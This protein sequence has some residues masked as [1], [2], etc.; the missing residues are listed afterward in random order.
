STS[1]SPPPPPPLGAA[2]ARPANPPHPAAP[3]P[4]HPIR[5]LG[6]G[7]QGVLLALVL[8][9]LAGVGSALV[10][11]QQVVFDRDH[12]LDAH[13]SWMSADDNVAAVLVVG[14]ALIVA[15]LVLLS[16]LTRRAHR[17]LAALDPEGLRWSASWA[18]WLWLIPGLTLHVPW[19]VLDEPRQVA[20]ASRAGRLE[21]DSWRGPRCSRLG[22]WWFAVVALSVGSVVGATVLQPESL[23]GSDQVTLAVA[24]SADRAQQ[25]AAYLVLVVGFAAGAVAAGLGIAYVRRLVRVLSAPPRLVGVTTPLD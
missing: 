4:A 18:G 16:L 3:H 14:G 15:L 17:T 5:G 8:V 9:S 23:S 2:P 22:W 24:G 6:R 1:S 21:G 10:A 7:V 20:A 19:L 11:R 12:P 13:S 25:R